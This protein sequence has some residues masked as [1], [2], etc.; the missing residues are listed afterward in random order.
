[1]FDDVPKFSTYY[2][3]DLAQAKK[4]FEKTSWTEKQNFDKSFQVTMDIKARNERP[5]TSQPFLA[6]AFF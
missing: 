2:D 3:A 1:M 5:T 4:I 6:N